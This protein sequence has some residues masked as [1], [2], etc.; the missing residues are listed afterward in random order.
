MCSPAEERGGSGRNRMRGGGRLWR[1]TGRPS[2]CASAG[3]RL[4]L[5][6]APPR[7]SPFI[8]RGALGSL[9]AHAKD[10]RRRPCGLQWSCVRS[11]LRLGPDVF[12]GRARGRAGGLGQAGLRPVEQQRTGGRDEGASADFGDLGRKRLWAKK[13]RE[14]EIPFHFRKTVS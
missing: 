4:A 10:S 8:G 12:R 1:S 14:K 13:E 5:G 6:R 7:H 2:G 3:V 9:G 11:G